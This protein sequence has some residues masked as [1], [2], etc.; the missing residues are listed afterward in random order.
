MLEIELKP[1][2]LL[3]PL[4]YGLNT[5]DANTQILIADKPMII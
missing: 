4:L 3:T 1:D 2:A 5:L